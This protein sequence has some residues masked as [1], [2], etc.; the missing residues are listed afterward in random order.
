MAPLLLFAP[1][2]S[3]EIA[4]L[5]EVMSEMSGEVEEKEAR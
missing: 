4:R 3:S 2:N 1:V 5:A